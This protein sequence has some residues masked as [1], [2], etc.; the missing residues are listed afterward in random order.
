M[1]VD[2]T[3]RANQR[4]DIRILAATPQDEEEQALPEAQMYFDSGDYYMAKDKT[5]KAVLQVA[6]SIPT[7]LQSPTGKIIPT[8]ESVPSRNTSP[9]Q[10]KLAL[11]PSSGNSRSVEEEHSPHRSTDSLDEGKGKEED[12]V[13]VENL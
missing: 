13:P 9:V 6:P 10:S 3:I 2:F 5:R 12:P 4:G 11:E 1:W 7:I 8:V